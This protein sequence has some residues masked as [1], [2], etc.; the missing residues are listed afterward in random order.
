MFTLDSRP[1]AWGSLL[2][3][4]WASRDLVLTLARKDFLVRYRRAAFGMLWA[5]GMPLVQSLVLVVVFTL[6]VRIPMKTG[7]PFAVFVVAGITPWALFSG[8]AGSASTAVVDGAAMASKIYFPRLLLPLVILGSNLY[9]FAILVAIFFVVTLVF[10]V[11]LGVQVLLIVP[12][13][14]LLVLLSYG[15][16]LVASALH[17]YFRD[18]RFIVQASLSVWF[19]LTP[20]LYPVRRVPG[21]LRFVILGNP[22]TGIVELFRAATVGADAPLLLTVGICAAW[23][24]L[25]LALGLYLHRR[26][27]RLFTDLL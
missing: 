4:A 18:M 27:D 14:M 15:F 6:I 19:Y 12:A 21:A 3:R 5:V 24:G 23:T 7:V 13:I 10:G 22:V 11:H 20:I 9:G 26:F 17:V 1:E 16:G 2:A 8:V 25:L